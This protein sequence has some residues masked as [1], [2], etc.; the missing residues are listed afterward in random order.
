MFVWFTYFVD[1]GE[2]VVLVSELLVHTPYQWDYVPNRQK[3]TLIFANT[4][5]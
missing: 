4:N 2:D 1:D 5:W 3:R